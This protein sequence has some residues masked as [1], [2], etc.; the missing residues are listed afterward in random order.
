MRIDMK[1]N[2]TLKG[3][4]LVD[5]WG[6]SMTIVDF[7]EV[8]SETPATV[9]V[10]EI[11]SRVVSTDA[12]LSGTAVADQSKRTG[13]TYRARK[14]KADRKYFVSS[15]MHMSVHYLELWDGQPK[16]FNHCD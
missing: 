8:V 13:K 10:E 1:T 7:Y 5:V 12:Y 11:G 3:K 6:Y 4:I 9:V 2:E 14:P 15:L 16:Y